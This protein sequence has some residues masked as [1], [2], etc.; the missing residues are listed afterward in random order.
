MND[1]ALLRR[2][3]KPSE[4][5]QSLYVRFG[6]VCLDTRA[7]LTA[8]HD[9][10]SFQNLWRTVHN[11][12]A[13]K[14]RMEKLYKLYLTVSKITSA[15]SI[16]QFRSLKATVPGYDKVSM[17]FFLD[18]IAELISAGVL[19]V[20]TPTIDELKKQKQLEL[21]RKSALGTYHT[22]HVGKNER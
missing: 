17:S 21:L 12:S 20:N 19:I 14:D 1:E 22:T 3:R 11:P 15:F 16:E 2:M 4:V 10:E 18:D 7:T 5:N 6:S 13:R 8:V 9:F